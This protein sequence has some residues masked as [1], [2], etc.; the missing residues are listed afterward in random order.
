MWR[1][2]WE[3]ICNIIGLWLTWKLS[4]LILTSLVAEILCFCREKV[5]FISGECWW[6]SRCFSGNVKS[7]YMSS[8]ASGTLMYGFYFTC[9]SCRISTKSSFIFCSYVQVFWKVKSSSGRILLPKKTPEKFRNA[10]ETFYIPPLDTQNC[11][12]FFLTE[13]KQCNCSLVVLLIQTTSTAKLHYHSFTSEVVLWAANRSLSLILI[14]L[15][16]PCYKGG[17]KQSNLREAR[18]QIGKR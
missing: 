9:R 3:R 15:S 18:N 14:S 10:I 8:F 1:Y 6:W 11:K 12:E 2:T 13:K 17:R 7:P 4:K 16:L 5:H